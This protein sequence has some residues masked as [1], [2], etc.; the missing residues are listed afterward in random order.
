M[1]G[2]LLRLALRK[3]SCLIECSAFTLKEPQTC[4][5]DRSV[6]LILYQ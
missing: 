4:I 6:V 5:S 1:Y 2:M 3:T